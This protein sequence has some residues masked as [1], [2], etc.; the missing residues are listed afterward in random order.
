MKERFKDCVNRLNR[1]LKRPVT[2]RNLV[3][4]VIISYLT[5]LVIR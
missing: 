1:I 2:N 3:I 4:I 5:S